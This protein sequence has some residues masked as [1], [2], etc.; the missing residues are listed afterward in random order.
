MW[1]RDYASHAEA[2][3]DVANYTAGFY[4]NERFH[5][6]FGNLSSSINERKMAEE[7]LIVGSETT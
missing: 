6:V 3:F 2:K 7:E 4:N 1:Q 5:S